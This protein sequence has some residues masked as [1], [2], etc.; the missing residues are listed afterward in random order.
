[1]MGKLAGWCASVNVSGMSF[2][3]SGWREVVGGE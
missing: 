1:M 3:V 2:P